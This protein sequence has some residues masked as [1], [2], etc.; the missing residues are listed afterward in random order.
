MF[1]SS[2]LVTT[3]T[4]TSP[5]QTIVL[6]FFA[7]VGLS[8]LF[9]ALRKVRKMAANTI[10]PILAMLFVVYVFIAPIPQSSYPSQIQFLHGL[11]QILHG[12]VSIFVDR[13]R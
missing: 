13:F 7:L 1:F 2:L 4:E 5:V 10:V 12:V 9:A 6:V 8:L 11:V 3:V